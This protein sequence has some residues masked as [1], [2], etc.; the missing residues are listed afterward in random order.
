[1]GRWTGPQEGYQLPWVKDGFTPCSRYLGRK[2]PCNSRSQVS[3]SPDVYGGGGGVQPC[4]P[5]PYRQTYVGQLS[6]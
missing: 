3:G 6:V 5:R 2:G 4:I 1:M